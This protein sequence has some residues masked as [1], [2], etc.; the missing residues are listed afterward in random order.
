MGG[1]FPVVLTAD[2]MLFAGYRTLFEGM[3]SASQTSRTPSLLMKHLLAPVAR[4][5]GLRAR[6]APLGLRRVESALAR[7][8]WERPDVA[9]VPPES[10]GG[11]IGPETRIIGISS[12]DP[13]GIGM[14]STT[15]SGVVG[16]EILTSRWFR[17]LAENVLRLRRRAPNARVVMG[18]AGAWQFAGD[19]LA[20]R[21]MG[22]DHV[23]RGYCEGNVAGLFEKIARGENLSATLAG[24]RVA[25]ADL[26]RILGPTLMGGVEISR[27][28]GLGC[29]F[30]TLAGEPM[31]HP[32]AEA[33]LADVETNLSGGVTDVV[34]VTEDM[35]RYGGR[36][37]QTQPSALI[38]LLERLRAL[39]RVRLIQADHAN[40]ASAAQ[41]S[42][43]ELAAV[44]R[45]MRGP[46]DHAQ[47]RR[48]DYLWLN[49]GVETASGGLLAANGGRRK[50]GGGDPAAWDDLCQEQVRRLIRL[51]FFPLVSLVLGM[52]G[53]TQA[54]VERTIRWV[55]RLREERLAVFPVFHAP[56][57]TRT[58]P[59][60]LADMSAA[61]WRLFRECYELNFR[62][63]PR[64]LWDNQTA[65]RVPLWRRAA[66][67]SL[68]RA[69]TLWWKSLFVWRSGTIR[70]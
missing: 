53:E 49:L 13:L 30:C 62:W 9:V 2:R 46:F 34:L 26:P 23:I 20:Q 5:D 32:P 45:A 28:C 41:F 64:L 51:G 27:G 10:L 59:F 7:S 47:G 67:Q 18:G 40:I 16:G 37:A 25:A 6:Q 58:G 8:G 21:A 70:P 31:E 3:I 56:T 48:N 1:G 38:A 60:G 29:G 50:M 12:G 42:D 35:F 4:R 11:A 57:K 19:R 43:E 68:G 33:V 39:P 61:H 52:P 17:E 65:S 63:I 54:D 36:G 14:N 44:R 69:Q 66:L 24:E 15:M 22:V 55:A